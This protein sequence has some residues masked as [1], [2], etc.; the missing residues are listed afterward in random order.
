MKNEV[1]QISDLA[2]ELG[3][4]LQMKFENDPYAYVYE[5]IMKAFMGVVDIT[6]NMVKN[7]LNDRP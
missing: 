5:D 1:E 6:G 7:T 4:K 2:K 3:T